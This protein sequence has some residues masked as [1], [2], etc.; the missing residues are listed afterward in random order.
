[1]KHKIKIL[2]T[3][4]LPAA[5]L[6]PSCKKFLDTENPSSI[7]QDA[8]FNSLSYTES[9][10]TGIYAMLIGD[11]GYGNR[12]SCLYPQTA[13]DFKTSGSYSPL[14]R[15]GIS[16]YGAAPGNTELLNPFRQLYKGIERANI[17]IK[18]IP[19]SDLYKNGTEAEKQTMRRLY[20]EALTLRAQFYYELI[21]NW[22]DVPFHEL[23]AADL[24]DLFLPKTDRDEIYDKMIADL[25]VAA[26]LVPW[27]TAGV[28]G[29]RVTK[30]YTKGLR[31]RMALARGG[32]SLRRAE[33]QY[34]QTM[35]RPADYLSFYQIAKDETAAIIAQSGEHNL[36]PDYESLFRSIH[37]GAGADEANEI[38]FQVGA[39]GGNASTDSKIGYYN[40]VR[41]NTSSKYGGGGGGI[42]A[43]ASYF[44][45]FDSIGDVRR[46]VTIG[47]FEIDASNN[48]IMNTLGN[49]TEGKYRRSWTSIT[50]TSQN[51]AINWIILRYADVL[52][53]FAEADNELN[54]G[55]TAE[56]VSAYEQVRR[57]AFK[58]FEDRMGTTPTGKED[59][60]AALVQERLLEFGGEGIRKYDLIRW[61]LLN[62]KLTETRAKLTELMN[63]TGRYANIP[64]YIHV[65]ANSYDPAASS[66]EDMETIDFSGGIS[67]AEAL[68]KPND[69]SAAPSGYTTKNWRSSVSTESISGQSSGLATFFIPNAR[70][71]YPLHTDI[72]T[73]NYKL[74]QDYGY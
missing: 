2:L 64:A 72:I 53:M 5:T 54:G 28:G 3:A 23:P 45:E 8:V 48:K 13:D 41:H 70:E 1:M 37:S 35:A 30:A 27:R 31:A 25:A 36:N 33:S 47:T 6:L 9:A 52:L 4:L 49:M 68:F 20:G 67:A 24:T 56:A 50:G 11:N 66:V 39:F 59:F 69:E 43:V 12:I 26:E 42:N 74:K 57:R 38:I 7:S 21:R 51:L 18:Y 10:V 32:Y 14:D 29:F 17:C 22:G 61:N 62:T 58:G 63:G 34:G 46:D 44:Y 71:L 60:F 40:G 73:E 19:E 55:A 15:R 16:M 65:K